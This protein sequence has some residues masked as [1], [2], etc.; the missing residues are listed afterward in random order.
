M[1]NSLRYLLIIFLFL[2]LIA[3]RAFIEPYF[4]DPLI[5]FFKTDYL[6][7]SLPDI[8]FPK[9][10]FNIGLRY[11]LNSLISLFII[12]LVFKKKNTLLFSIKFYLISFVILSIMLF[13]LLKYSTSFNYITIFYVRRLLIQPLF[14]LVLLPAFY[15]Q[16]LKY[17]AFLL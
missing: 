12:F 1:R 15:Y 16:K 7:R 2:C 9:Y 13:I 5:V 6:N 11:F 10:F 3:V 4:Y 14:L 17:S 8:D